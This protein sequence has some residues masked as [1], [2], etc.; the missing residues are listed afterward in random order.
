MEAPNQGIVQTPE[1][2]TSLLLAPFEVFD[3]A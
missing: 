2:A 1:L 3:E